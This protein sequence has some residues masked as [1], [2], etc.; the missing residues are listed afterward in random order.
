[1]ILQKV[2]T[3]DII[4]VWNFGSQSVFFKIVYQVKFEKIRSSCRWN[5]DQNWAQNYAKG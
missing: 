4:S 5:T 2:T 1:M 3:V